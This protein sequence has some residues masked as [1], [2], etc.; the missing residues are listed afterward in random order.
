MLSEGVSGTGHTFAE[1]IGATCFYKIYKQ[2][3]HPSRG[4][5][6]KKRKLKKGLSEKKVWIIS[7][8]ASEK[9]R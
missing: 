6:F 9:T 8:R 1:T 4:S 3:L 5:F 7:E 2:E